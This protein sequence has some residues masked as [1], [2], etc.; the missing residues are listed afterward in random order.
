MPEKLDLS[1]IRL[2][3]FKKYWSLHRLFVHICG[4]PFICKCSSLF[5]IKCIGNLFLL[6]FFFS[7]SF[8]LWRILSLF[9]LFP[10]AF[11]LFSFITHFY[12]SLLE[13]N[14][15]RTEA[16]NVCRKSVSYFLSY[17]LRYKFRAIYYY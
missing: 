12:F 10:S 15:R 17:F 4:K 7:S 2:S 8:F 11:I 9:L 5:V 3:K 14:L 13:N 1:L 16:P 6:L